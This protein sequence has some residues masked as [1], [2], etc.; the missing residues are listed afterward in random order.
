MKFSNNDQQRLYELAKELLERKVSDAEI[1]KQLLNRTDDAPII[2][3]IIRRLKTEQ[4]AIQRRNGLFKI[5]SGAM[6]LLVGFLITCV[7]F[8]SNQ[9]FTIVMYS[10]SLVGLILIFWGLHD[11]FG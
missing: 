7:N 1:K 5:V 4:Y 2:E 3:G 10:T 8:H 11:L 6:S 9:S